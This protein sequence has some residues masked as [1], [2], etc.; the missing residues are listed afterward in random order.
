MVFDLIPLAGAV[1]ALAIS[2][3]LLPDEFLLGVVEVV[4]LMSD[5]VL[6]RLFYL[7]LF[8]FLV[9]PLL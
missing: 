3:R 5:V 4:V 1:F 8:I 7:V 6:F 2:K 9:K